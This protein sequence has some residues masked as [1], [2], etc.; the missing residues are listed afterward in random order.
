MKFGIIKLISN[1]FKKELWFIE[2]LH[3]EE[4]YNALC[5]MDDQHA[6]HSLKEIVALEKERH[7]KVSGDPDA[8][9]WMRYFI[10]KDKHDFSYEVPKLVWKLLIPRS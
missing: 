7:L 5:G 6:A 4:A 1:K 3:L 9:V 10:G 2:N 8:Y